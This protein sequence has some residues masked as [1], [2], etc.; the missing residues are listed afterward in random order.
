MNGTSIKW[1]ASKGN[2]ISKQ[3][4][5]RELE[6]FECFYRSVSRGKYKDK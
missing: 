4:L 6:L 5:M 1:N 2:G 3:I